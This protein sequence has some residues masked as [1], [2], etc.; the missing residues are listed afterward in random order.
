MMEQR[1]YLVIAALLFLFSVYATV[2]SRHILR[3]LIAL[4]A[5]G[6]SV[7]LVF[8]V[9]S[10]RDEPADPV[11][12]AMV[13]TGLVVAVAASG[14]GVALARKSAVEAGRSTLPEDEAA[15]GGGA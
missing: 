14:F 2:A 6:A 9:L 4:N 11:P 13:L 12:Q 3:R 15:K 1:F 7:F 10:L 8:V 5:M